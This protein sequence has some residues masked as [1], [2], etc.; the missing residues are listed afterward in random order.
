MSVFRADCPYCY[1]RSVAFEITG[2][3]ELEGHRA[4]WDVLAFCARCDRGVVATFEMPGTDGPEAM[5]PGV[6]PDPV[7][8]FP[9]PPKT[10]VPEHTPK[11][12][13]NYFRQGRESLVSGNWDAAGVMYRKA[14]ETCLKQKFPQYNRN[15]SLYKRIERAEM[16][17][18]LT[19]DLA[20]WG[21]Q[22]RILG[23]DAGH[24]E[25]PFARH[26]AQ[27]LDRF[28]EMLLLYLYTLPGWL[29]AAREGSEE[30]KSE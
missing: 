21:H 28:T 17:G 27:E 20:E 30:D 13:G 3:P 16:D 11:N 14:L 2:G 10:E 19:K 4:L 5:N 9:S 7:A 18:A 23:N 25:E 6:L 26:D 8:I 12:V 24:E 1:T 22:I 29:S 15:D